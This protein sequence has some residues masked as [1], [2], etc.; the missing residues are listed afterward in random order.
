MT[1]SGVGHPY[2]YVGISDVLS[3]TEWAALSKPG[4]SLATSRTTNTV[5]VASQAIACTDI[6]TSTRSFALA[7]GFG[8]LDRTHVG[9]S[10]VI[11][12]QGR[13]TATAT[14]IVW[15]TT[16]IYDHIIGSPSGHRLLYVERPG[17]EEMAMV[18]DIVNIDEPG[19]EENGDLPIT[20][21]LANAVSTAPTWG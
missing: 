8:R 12:H 16:D 9:S 13:I 20:V 5:T 15:P 10:S 2:R 18:C 6:T 1:T 11:N 7:R 21:E 17:N 4:V 14:L 3:D 19:P